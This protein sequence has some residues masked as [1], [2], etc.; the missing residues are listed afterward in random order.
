MKKEGWRRPAEL[1]NRDKTEVQQPTQ[2]T[3]EQQRKSIEWTTEM[4]IVLVMLDEDERAKGRGFMK[5]VK[6]RW[7]MKYPEHE[8]ASW[9]E[10]SD[11]AARF[12]KDPEI[13]NLILVRRREGV[14]VAE[15]AIENNPEEEG[16]IV[17]PVVNKDEEEQV[18]VDVEVVENVLINND[19][20]LSK[21]NKELERYF[22][23]ELEN[24]NHSTLLHMEPREKLP[25]VKMSDEIEERANKILYLYLPSA[26]T[27]P[28]ITDIVYV[29]GKAIGYA[30]GIKPKE[31]NENRPKKAQCGNRRERKL[32]AEMKELRQ[33]VARAGNELHRRKHQRKSTKKEKRILK[34]LRTKMNGKEA[35]SKNLR[36][37]KEQWLDKRRYKKKL[38]K[39]IEKRNRKKHNI[40]FQRD[41]KGFFRTLEAVEKRKGEI[42]EMGAKRANTNYAVDE[43]GES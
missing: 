11:N 14:Q 43:R 5:R 29:M 10:L 13:K 30:T 18:A 38:E 27:I 12:K 4:K 31:G 3:G 37:V 23:S 39:Y 7:D 6:D 41:Q 36:I 9:Q 40:L 16:N 15:V 8:S 20:K 19:E 2:V 22:Q 17:E 25:K 21:K 42:P 26:D 34:E 35:T 33:D 1:E 28:E 24:L 32:K